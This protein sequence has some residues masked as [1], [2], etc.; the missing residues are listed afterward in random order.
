MRNL[1]GGGACINYSQSLFYTGCLL[2]SSHLLIRTTYPGTSWDRRTEVN[3]LLVGLRSPE[4]IRRRC[5]RP[6]RHPI[7]PLSYIPPAPAPGHPP[8]APVK[9]SAQ[10]VCP[11]YFS[12]P[13]TN[14]T[15]KP[16]SVLRQRTIQYYPVS[17]GF[18]LVFSSDDK[19]P[20]NIQGGAVLVWITSKYLALSSYP[21][22]IAS[23]PR[24]ATLSY[25]HTHYTMASIPRL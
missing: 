4:Q 12:A 25:M 14:N 24:L 16:R 5:T 13:L 6:N 15:G 20:D 18:V 3:T 10:W 19:K 2:Y 11:L 17:P 9:T 1:V 22:R 8:L 21:L 23:R 7:Y